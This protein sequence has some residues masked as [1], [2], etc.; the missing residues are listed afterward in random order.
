MGPT[1][2]TLRRPDRAR[3]AAPTHPRVSARRRDVARQHGRRRLVVLC[4]VA[5]A[6]T[7]GALA[8]PVLHSRWFAARAVNIS[9]SLHTPR[10]AVL[11]AAGLAGA[12]PMIDV[13]VGAAQARLDALPWV[14][15][16]TVSLSWPDGVDVTITERVAVAVV[17][18]GHA[19][20][21]LDRSGRVLADAPAAPDGLVPVSLLGALG[22]P[23]STVRRNSEPALVVAAALPPVLRPSVALVAAAPD[24]SVTLT[25]ASGVH[26]AFGQ[27]SE[28]TAK[29]EDIAAIEAGA[30][31]GPHAVLDVSVPQSPTV[32]GG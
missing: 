13:R 22:P 21:E 1:D 29:F 20:A 6:M 11:Q 17:A 15:R 12:P 16:A 10:A 32:S 31:P 8:W 7:L 4:V 18:D 9:G 23:G 27:A 24:G 2:T 3:R 19:F 14:Q 25:L 30:P 28:L 5:S 26:V